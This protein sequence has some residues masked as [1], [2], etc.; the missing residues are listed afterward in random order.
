VWRVDAALPIE[1]LPV[2][3][4]VPSLVLSGGYDPVT[5]PTW[6]ALAASTLS[7]STFLELSNEAHGAFENGCARSTIL[8]FATDPSAPLDV[9][10]ASALPTLTFVTP[11]PT[12]TAALVRSW[13]PGDR[14]PDPVIASILRQVRQARV[15]WMNGSAR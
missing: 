8:R 6:S 2:V 3:S 12:A 14:L 7:R 13:S 10:C 5:P 1:H 4:D 9:S 15:R 11:P